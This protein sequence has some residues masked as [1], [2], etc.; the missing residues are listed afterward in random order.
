MEESKGNEFIQMIRALWNEQ[1]K[2]EVLYLEALKKE[3]M[4]PFRRVLSQGHVSALLFQKEIRAVY[5][6]FKCFLNDKELADQNQ[7]TSRT[8]LQILDNANGK[9]EVASCLKKIEATV[10][11]LYKAISGYLEKEPE[12]QRLMDEHLIRTSEFHEMLCKLESGGRR[13]YSL[14]AAA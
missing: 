6:Y 1:K 11:Q 3:G 2:R 13:G 8:S 10:M 7:I 4:G 14:T 5:D 12:A 9:E